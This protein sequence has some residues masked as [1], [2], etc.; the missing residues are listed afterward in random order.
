M[1][2]PGPP[3]PNAAPPPELALLHSPAARAVRKL[4]AI[5]VRRMLLLSVIVAVAAAAGVGLATRLGETTHTLTATMVYT[6]LPS[7]RELKEVYD[8]PDLKTLLT[9]L[10]T[11]DTLAKL[12]EEFQTGVPPRVL[13][14]LIEVDNPTQTATVRLTLGWSDADRGAQ[15]LDKLMAYYSQRV[16]EMR[17]VKLRG[18]VADLDR[19]TLHAERRRDEAYEALRRFNARLGVEDYDG[20]PELVTKRIEGMEFQ[21][22]RLLVEEKS[23]AKLIADTKERT[24]RGK[25][26]AEEEA[27]REAAESAQTE[28]V[29]EMRQRQN[30]MSEKRRDERA[31]LQVLAQIESKRAE[32][33]RVNNL[34]RQHFASVEEVEALKT[35]LRVLYAKVVET[36]EIATLTEEIQKLDEAVIPSK[37]PK[38][39]TSPI[40]TQLLTT[41]MQHEQDLL[42]T[43]VK[44]ETLRSNLLIERRLLENLVARRQEG[45]ALE[46]EVENLSQQV[47][48]VAGQ[49]A[50]FER[51][52]A[53]EPHEFTVTAPASASLEAPASNRKKMAV[54]GFAPVLLLLAGPLLLWDLWKARQ[55]D[56]SLMMA[57]HGLP[58]L[59]PPKPPPGLLGP[60]PFRRSDRRRWCDQVAL[61]LQQLSPRVGAAVLVSPHRFEA[62]TAEMWSGV[63]CSLASREE[64]VLVVLA[65]TDAAQNAAHLG[66]AFDPGGIGD[67][68]NPPPQTPG[69]LEHLTTG[70]GDPRDLVQR[71]P[72]P[73]VFV[74]P[75]GGGVLSTPLL[76]SK[77]MDALME[78]V[79][80][81]Y[82]SI[83]LAGPDFADSI[84]VE[85]LTRFSDGVVV[86]CRENA[87]FG[88]DDTYCLESL[89]ELDTPVWG[90]A[91]R[92]DGERSDE[93]APPLP[94]VAAPHAA[95]V[96]PQAGMPTEA[97]LKELGAKRPA[98]RNAP[99][100]GTATE[101]DLRDLGAKR[102][103]PA[104]G[105]ETLLE[106]IED[107]AA[108]TADGDEAATD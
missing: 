7:A 40:I 66:A 18:Y 86:S 34:Y 67:E 62:D 25:R 33:A 15:L 68:A 107:F 6:P 61:R 14:K 100:A 37:E 99:A 3:P 31:K 13:D 35:E 50:A 32:L 45:E 102:P 54:L 9:F 49:R 23:I 22:A 47:A 97:D 65:S 95:D 103:D 59:S 29:T 63:A 57:Q 98:G 78:A 30:R 17:R 82:T 71:T 4:P 19:A 80:Q 88:A 2:P 72:Y 26:Q 75:A 21:L 10:K 84:T 60:K 36:P 101:A 55:P 89:L 12:T 79:R 48:I 92:P 87:P 69:L 81:D 52:L 44:I 51:L 105:S 1:T 16:A 96:T 106:R 94:V 5:L 104:A 53:Y 24:L 73:G 74:L 41:E 27:A 20:A 38:V 8:P 58:D 108:I 90:V 64:R 42:G 85:V 39:K 46:Q 70:E 28:S 76:A 91:V 43:Q 93:V 11:P 77:R 56:V 83:L